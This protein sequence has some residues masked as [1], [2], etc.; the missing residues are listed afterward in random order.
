MKTCCSLVEGL[1][2]KYFLNWKTHSNLFF[3][4]QRTWDIHAQATVHFSG[5][6]TV[7]PSS[8]LPNCAVWCIFSG[9]PAKSGTDDW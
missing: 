9:A 1:F 2:Y 5:E 7:C 8:Y 6:S 3:K 4:G